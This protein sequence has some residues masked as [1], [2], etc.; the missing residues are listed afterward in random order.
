[1]GEGTIST[2]PEQH[3]AAYGEPVLLHAF[4]EHQVALRPDHP[5]VECKG[6]NSHL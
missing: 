2:A 1:M 4:F 3:A 6:E 5:A